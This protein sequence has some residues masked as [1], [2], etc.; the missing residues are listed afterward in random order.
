[1]LVLYLPKTN[2]VEIVRV[3][4]GSRELDALLLRE[5]L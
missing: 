5:G 3:V 2:E 4:H 1:M